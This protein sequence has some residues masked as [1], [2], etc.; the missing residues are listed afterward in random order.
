LAE[1]LLKKVQAHREDVESQRAAVE[2]LNRPPI[3]LAR[4][5]NSIKLHRIWNYYLQRSPG[6]SCRLTQGISNGAGGVL[7]V[8]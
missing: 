7:N 6:C 8:T 2:S 1:A 4:L 5:K 3:P